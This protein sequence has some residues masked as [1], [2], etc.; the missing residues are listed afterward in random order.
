MRRIARIRAPIPEGRGP[1]PIGT[2][3]MTGVRMTIRPR[4]LSDFLGGWS[5]D[6]RIDQA[7][8]GTGRFTGQ[9]R[10]TPE[11]AGML[12]AETGQLALD[13]H[14]PMQAERR[15]RWDPGLIVR[16]EDGRL[17]HT[18][19]PLGGRTSHWCDPDRYEAHY[20]FADWPIFRVTWTV[21]GP[22]KDYV[23]TSVYRP[24]PQHGG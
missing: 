22:R 3:S 8:G 1:C 21:R 6:R 14:P 24:L 15:Y 16:F 13:G 7:D 19:P 10:W 20:D 12:Y 5:L 2:G 11:G 9:A 23:M 4:R 18:V 17:F